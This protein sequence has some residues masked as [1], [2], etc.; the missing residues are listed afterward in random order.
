MNTQSSL[1][2]YCCCLLFAGVVE[3]KLMVDGYDDVYL[4]IPYIGY[5]IYVDMLMK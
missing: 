5:H 2:Y 1:Y 4:P 3:S